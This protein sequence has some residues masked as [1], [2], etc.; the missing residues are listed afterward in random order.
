MALPATDT[1]TRADG[2]LAAGSANW[3]K[4]NASSGNMN[5]NANAVASGSIN[6]NG[7]RWTADTFDADHYSQVVIAALTNAVYV[8]PA[9]RVQNGAYTYYGWYGDT[10]FSYPFKQVAGTWTQF[11]TTL[12]VFVV[13]QT[14]RV[15]A[16]GT[17]I[18]FLRNGVSERT[19]TDS[20][21]AGGFAGL[22]GQGNNNGT[23]MDTWEGGDAAPFDPG[24]GVDNTYLTQP[25]YVR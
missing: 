17:T 12:P 11:G 22:T 24:P 16:T 7:Y 25:L 18:D 5:V 14:I 3:A 10:N 2:E 4:C 19:Q 6:E 15:A 21:I 1:F 8:G 23:K 9:C 13:G 20:A